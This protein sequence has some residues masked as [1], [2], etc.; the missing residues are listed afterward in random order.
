MVNDENLVIVS[1][2]HLSAGQAAGAACLSPKGSSHP[3]AAFARFLDHLRRHASRR[4]RELRLL[5]LGDLFDFSRA[6]AGQPL[7]GDLCPDTSEAATLARLQ[8]IADG[9]PAVFGALRRLLGAGIPLDIVPGN[10]DI[11]LMRPSAQERLGALLSEGSHQVATG[12]AFHPWMYYVPGLLYAEHGHQYHDINSFHTLLSPYLPGS[13]DTIDLPLGTYLD[14]YLLSI[15]ARLNR[16]DHGHHGTPVGT[17]AS[18]VARRS[19]L[20]AAWRLHARV[21]RV[22]LGRLGY[23]S[24]RALVARRT[25]YRSQFLAPYAATVGLGQETVIA[26]DRLSES[27]AAAIAWRL[28]TRFLSRMRVGMPAPH[29]LYAACLRIDRLLRATGQGVPYYVF[30]HSHSPTQRPL[31]P[32]AG[33]PVC[34]NCG[35]WAAPTASHP[36]PERGQGWPFIEIAH[37][38]PGTAPAA[39]LLYWGGGED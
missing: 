10:H 5:I 27:S 4:A 18:E 16:R 30:G 26:I 28:L 37:G 14:L 34:L 17:P 20:L 35:A 13:P 2:L 21:L 3:D 38:R 8:Q 36:T 12:I 7:P 11:E 9:H 1:D 39:R 6:G 33:A 15:T 23:R 31:A 25:A 32:G 29:Y 22:A 24:S 19:S